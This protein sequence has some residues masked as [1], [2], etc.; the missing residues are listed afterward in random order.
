ME[1]LFTDQHK[2]VAKQWVSLP[3][4]FGHATFH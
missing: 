4:G 3:E 1:V 2:E